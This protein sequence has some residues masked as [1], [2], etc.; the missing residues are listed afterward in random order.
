MP[1]STLLS[2]PHCNNI[3]EFFG[4]PPKPEHLDDFRCDCGAVLEIV[5]VGSDIDL[6][7]AAGRAACR[8]IVAARAARGLVDRR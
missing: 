1:F 6:D 4:E 2:C 7:V 8:S 5:Q 3:S